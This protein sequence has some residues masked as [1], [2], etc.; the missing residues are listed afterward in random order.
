M[1]QSGESK[2]SRMSWKVFQSEQL[3]HDK[4]PQLAPSYSSICEVSR[5]PVTSCTG[6]LSALHF[7]TSAAILSAVQEAVHTSK[8]GNRW[9]LIGALGGP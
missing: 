9:P 3:I 6:V 1:T 8:V 7:P 4:L 2:H 5:G